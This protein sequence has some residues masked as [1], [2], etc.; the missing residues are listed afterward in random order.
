MVYEDKQIL[1]L[2]KPSG[3]LSQKDM[4]G[5][6]D[7]L[8]WS[9]AFLKRTHGKPGN[10]FSGLVHRLDLPVGGLMVFAKNSKAAKRMSGEFG[11]RLVKKRYLAICVGDVPMPE[12]RVPEAR[13]R[14]AESPR[15]DHGESPAAGEAFSEAISGAPPSLTLK[16]ELFRDNNVTRPAEPGEKSK[17]AVLSFAV[18]GTRVLDD[19]E[20]ASLLDVDLLTGF[21]HQIRAQLSLAGAPVLGDE[22]YGGPPPPPGEISIGLFSRKLGFRHPATGEIVTFEAKPP[23]AVWPWNLFSSSEWIGDRRSRKTGESGERKS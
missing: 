16:N 12:A 14:E 2:D 11:K 13:G 23:G 20:T 19:G 10:A 3:W 9:K 15:E 8:S 1:V 5:R 18:L 22:R 17:P 6:P 21:K 7:I 4:S